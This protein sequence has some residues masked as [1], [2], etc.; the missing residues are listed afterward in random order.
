MSAQ[1]LL[2]QGCPSQVEI[3][4]PGAQS[5]LSSGVQSEFVA[6]W[7]LPHG[8]VKPWEPQVAGTHHQPGET[9]DVPEH[10][11]PLQVTLVKPALHEQVPSVGLQVALAG[12]ALSPH[13]TVRLLGPQSAPQA[14]QSS[15]QLAQVS[16]F[17]VSQVPSPQSGPSVQLAQVVRIP[18]IHRCHQSLVVDSARSPFTS[19]GPSDDRSS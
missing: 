4:E 19:G 6:Q 2:G 12:H 10:A 8:T 5:H 7:P 3:S 9:Q 13:G 1:P 16:P 11:S 15:G 17:D 18:N 14:P